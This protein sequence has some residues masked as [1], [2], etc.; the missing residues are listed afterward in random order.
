M[1]VV[2]RIAA[3]FFAYVLACIAGAIVFTLGLL[4]WQWNEFAWLASP[5]HLAAFEIAITAVIFAVIALP[6][7]ALVIALGEGFALRSSLFY[8]VIGGALALAA[9][10]G[11][12]MA[13]YVDAS[14]APAARVREVL[15]ATGI[16]GGLVYWLVAG[17][18][19]GMWHR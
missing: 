18:R 1:A 4:A 6:P 8:A 13:D 16:A 12:N 9:A 11:L 2:A 17:R 15:A 14:A 5:G 19:A 10:F 7:A 3:V